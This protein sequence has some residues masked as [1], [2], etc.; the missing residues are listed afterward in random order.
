MLVCSAVLVASLLSGCVSRSITYG[1]ATYKSLRFASSEIAQEVSVT[2]TNGT[3]IKITGYNNDNTQVIGAAV[4][5]AIS[6]T[7]KAFVP[8]AK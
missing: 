2:T 7:A 4:G 5:A 3:V 8:T 1:G 6:A